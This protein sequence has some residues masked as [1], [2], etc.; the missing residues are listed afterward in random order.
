MFWLQVM[1]S[2]ILR[3]IAIATRS[4]VFAQHSKRH[5]QYLKPG[6]VNSGDYFGISVSL[7]G[8][9]MVVGSLLEDSCAKGVNALRNSDV[10]SNSGAAYVYVWDQLSEE[11]VQEAY[12]KASN[13]GINYFFGW[14]V[15]LWENLLA[16]AA[17]YEGSCSTGVNSDQTSS[18]CTNAG[19]VYIFER[20]IG[21]GQWSQQA[22]LKAS[23]TE[24]NDNFGWSVGVWGNK[25]VVGTILEDSSARTINGD[26]NDNKCE[27]GGATYIFSRDELTR[28]WSQEVYLK[29]SNIGVTDWFGWDCS[30]W[31]DKVLVSS[32]FEDSAG[33]LDDNS[34][35]DAGAVY[36]FTKDALT[37]R[38]SQEAYLK[39][40]HFRVGYDFSYNFF[41]YAVQVRHN[42]IVIGSVYD[43]SCYEWT[44]GLSCAET[45]SG[46]VYI[47]SQNQVD[48]QWAMEAFLKATNAE[49]DNQFGRDVSIW[50]TGDNKVLVVGAFAERG[51]S[52]G[53]DGNQNQSAQGGCIQAGAA[54]AFLQNPWTAEWT[55]VVY[56]KSANTDANDQF[57]GSVSVYNSTS[58]VVG[59]IGEGSCSLDPLD[60]SCPWAG[61]A[62]FFSLDYPSFSPPSP[63]LTSSPSCSSSVPIDAVPSSSL[64]SL[65]SP[66]PLAAAI[67]SNS[68]DPRVWASSLAAS[69]ATLVI[70]YACYRYRR[71]LCWKRIKQKHTPPSL[72]AADF[73]DQTSGHNILHSATNLSRSTSLSS[74]GAAPALLH[75][76]S[77]KQPSG[78]GLQLSVPGV[79]VDASSSSADVNASPL[80]TN[81]HVIS[82]S[83]SA[84]VKNSSSPGANV[85]SSAHTVYFGDA[86]NLDLKQQMARSSRLSSSSPDFSA[87]SSTPDAIKALQAAGISPGEEGSGT[88]NKHEAGAVPAVAFPSYVVVS[89]GEELPGQISKGQSLITRDERGNII[90]WKNTAMRKDFASESVESST[91]PTPPPEFSGA[92]PFDSAEAAASSSSQSN[93]ADASSSSESNG[94][95]F[96]P[97]PND[98]THAFYPCTTVTLMY[99]QRRVPFKYTVI[100]R[101]LGELKNLVAVRLNK[102]VSSISLWLNGREAK[103]MDEELP[104]FSKSPDSTADSANFLVEVK[105]VFDIRPD[106]VYSPGSSPG[107]PGELDSEYKVSLDDIPQEEY[108]DVFK[109]S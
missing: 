29:P 33:S 108:E 87:S 11:W 100:H 62:Y 59:A 52:L 104:V 96:P 101:T 79:N 68:Q 109:S 67:S 21:T 60:N 12:L 85:S 22:Y 84:G 43:N 77:I 6:D 51:C 90:F 3:L 31:E 13:P 2:A 23:N 102:P 107:S 80:S 17:V 86:E 9:R 88:D 14:N 98:P 45:K 72:I 32:V 99:H 40:P 39:P 66:L 65:S 94:S 42:L 15:A 105:D 81:T 36:L 25:V 34:A 49:K 10:C 19:A 93:E 41:G 97:T 7:W 18:S 91:A 95:T 75:L 63:S 35:V 8:D 74:G 5:M 71:A 16:V 38:W 55:Q 1:A 48:G 78:G 30:I 26:Q 56:I 28:E 92:G 27:D 61:A 69:L 37:G 70:S 76:A 54:Y 58:L 50:G 53:I 57:G 73:P 106:N 24:T 103:N 46:A 83:S 20:D 64:A 47:F 4:T 82:S 89:A 44:L